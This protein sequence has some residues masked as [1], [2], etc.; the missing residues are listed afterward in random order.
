M[1][2]SSDFTIIED[3]ETRAHDK[4]QIAIDS[5]WAEISPHPAPRL[6]DVIPGALVLYDD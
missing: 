6:T 1:F 4:L 5:A 3:S 2:H